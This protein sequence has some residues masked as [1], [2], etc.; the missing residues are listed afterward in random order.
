[1]SE[2][3]LLLVAYAQFFTLYDRQHAANAKMPNG[4]C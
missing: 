4:L 3:R 1:M 2:V